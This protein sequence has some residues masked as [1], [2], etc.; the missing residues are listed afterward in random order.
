MVLV[1]FNFQFFSISSILK[2]NFGST[3]ARAKSVY[4]R[5]TFRGPQK[6]SSRDTSGPWANTLATPDLGRELSNKVGSFDD[7]SLQMIGKSSGS[8]SV[9][10][11]I[12]QDH[13]T[14]SLVND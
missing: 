4:I 14:T 6:T 1:P 9:F 5:K 10:G 3:L 13:W 11:K 7:N 12:H 2:K 8:L